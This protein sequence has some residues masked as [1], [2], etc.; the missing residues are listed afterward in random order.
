VREAQPLARDVALE[1]DDGIV[2]QRE[3][4]RGRVPPRTVA[5]EHGD[6]ARG[7]GPRPAP[8]EIGAEQ[9]GGAG[10]EHVAVAARG[11][12]VGTKA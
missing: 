8:N 9:A 2:R 5:H 6:A 7:A 10:D 12:E 1:H 4:A 11:V 3:A